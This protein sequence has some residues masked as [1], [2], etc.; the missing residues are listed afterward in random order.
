VIYER[1]HGGYGVLQPRENGAVVNGIVWFY[2]SLVDKSSGNN[3]AGFVRG[4]TRKIQRNQIK[5]D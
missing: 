1:N 3:A 5:P 2:A 4:L